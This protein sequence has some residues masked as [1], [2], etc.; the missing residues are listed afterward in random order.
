M[1]LPKNIR[2]ENFALRVN[3]SLA[4]IRGREIREYNPL[5]L[6]SLSDLYNSVFLNKVGHIDKM[7]KDYGFGT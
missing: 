4:V 7:L 5:H 6:P 3:E 1:Y 2:E